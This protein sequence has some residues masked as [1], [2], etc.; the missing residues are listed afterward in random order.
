[1][2]QI[3]LFI[4][5]CLGLIRGIGK[6]IHNYANVHTTVANLDEVV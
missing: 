2:G 6:P 3:S 1:M 5:D 4:E